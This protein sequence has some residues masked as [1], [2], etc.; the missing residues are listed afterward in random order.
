MKLSLKKCNF[1]DISRQW[2][3]NLE[4]TRRII[5]YVKATL[6]FFLFYEKRLSKSLRQQRLFL[7][8][9]IERIVLIYLCIRKFNFH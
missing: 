1:S 2:I 4:D 6:M 3:N 7:R 8:V 5:V 9:I